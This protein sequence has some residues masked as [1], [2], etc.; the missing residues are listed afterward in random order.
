MEKWVNMKVSQPEMLDIDLD[1]VKK[2]EIRET[3]M[4]N[5]SIPTKEG[6]QPVG[7]FIIN[8]QNAKLMSLM[9]GPGEVEAFGLYE[10]KEELWWRHRDGGT[11]HDFRVA[12]FDDMQEFVAFIDDDINFWD[13]V[14][15]TEARL[16]EFKVPVMH[17][18]VSEVKEFIREYE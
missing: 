15:P 17:M 11:T 14:L 3:E 9:F 4:F 2:D 8:M 12:A 5:R 18:K 6:Y 10:H 16:S 1:K 13:C 7:P